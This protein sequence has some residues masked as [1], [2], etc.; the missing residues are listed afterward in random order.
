MAYGTEIWTR[1][2]T[3]M[4]QRKKERIML[5]IIF[6]DRKSNTWIQQQD[7]MKDMPATIKTSKHGVAISLVSESIGRL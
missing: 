4:V 7:G 6:R 5:S 2:T 3:L 1:N